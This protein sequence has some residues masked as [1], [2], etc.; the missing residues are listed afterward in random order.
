MLLLL[1]LKFWHICMY[2][3][4]IMCVYMDRDTVSVYLDRDSIIIMI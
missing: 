4:E 1:F 3:R 2:M